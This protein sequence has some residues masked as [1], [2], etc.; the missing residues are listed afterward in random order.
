[1]SLNPDIRDRAYEF[2]IEEAQELLQ[3]LE[4]GLLEI[5]D[6]HSTPKVH[7][8]MRAAHSIK[9]G[10][11]SVELSAI[12]LLA[13]RLEDFFK[14]LYSDDIEFDGALESLLLQGYDCLSNPLTEQIES[15]A[16]DEEAALLSAEPVFAALEA[17]L[18]NA[19]KNAES[20][21]PSSNDLGVDIVSSIFE[22]DV[23]QSLEHLQEVAN[24]PN[25]YDLAE[26]LQGTL[27]MFA[28]FAELFSLPGFND[29]IQTAQ[30][31][32]ANNSDNAL[33]IIKA[34]IADCTLAKESVLAGDREQGGE[35]SNALIELAQASG[36]N[37]SSDN[38]ANFYA[39][40]PDDDMWSDNLTADPFA[41]DIFGTIPNAEVA[42]SEETISGEPSIENIGSI[43]DVFGA[44]PNAEVAASEDEVGASIEDIFGAIPD[45]EAV[46]SGETAPTTQN[47]DNIDSIDDVF[48]TI[49]D[50]EIAA[51]EEEVGAVDGI[52]DIFGSIP[53]VEA[54]VSE[55]TTPTQNT[56]N[57]DSIDE[58]F[59][60]IPDAE[61]AASE[62]EVGA[63]D[64]IEDIFGA[65]PDVEVTPKA[66]DKPLPH[67]NI[68]TAAESI[69]KIFDDLPIAESNLNSLTLPSAKETDKKPKASRAKSVQ[70]R[71]VQKAAAKLSV[72]VDLERLERMNNLVGELNINRNSLFLQNEQLQENVAELG[73]KF[74]RFRDVTQKLREISDRIVL[75]QRSHRSL[76][77]NLATSEGTYADTFENH[78]STEFDALEMDR[79]SGLYASIQNVLEEVVQLE[80]SVDDISIFAKQSDRTI[81]SQRQMLSQM[82]DELMW[83]RMLPLDQILQRFPRTL[84]DLSN[85]YQKPVDLKL[86]GTGVLV[87]KAVLEKLS[88]PLLHLLRNGFD[89]GIEPT[90]T[91]ISQG[92]NPTGKIEI[93]AYYQ[94]NQTVIE[95]KDDGKGLDVEKIAQKG[96]E[97][98]FISAAEVQTASKE[99][100]YD[101]IFEPGFSTANKVS[102]I[103]GRGVGMNIVRSQIESLKGKITVTS[104]PGEG[105]IFTLRLPLTLTIAKL[106]VC[107][108]GTTSFA[109]PSD[110]IEEIIIPTQEQIKLSNQQKFLS[111]G[112]KLVPI[113]CLKQLLQYNCPI[114]DLD[115][116]S[117]A[118]KTIKTPEDWFAPLLLLR[119]GQKLFALEVVSLLGEQEL[120]IKPYG[121]AIAAPQ[122]SYGCTILGDGSLIPAF[123]GATLI[124]TILGEEIAPITPRTEY[125]S[126]DTIIESDDSINSAD[127]FERSP[128]N[129]PAKKN[130]IA[131][132][133]IMVVDDSTALRRTMALTLEKHGYRVIQKKDGKDALDG[134]KQNPN[135]DLIICDVE[136][137]TM[138][139]FEFLGMRRRD[140]NLSQ[141]P[142]FMLTSRSG[143]KHRKLATQLGANG[144]FTKPYVEQEFILEVQKILSDKGSAR[145]AKSFESPSISKKTILVIDDSSALRRTLAFSLENKGYHVLQGR[146]GVEG[147]NLLRKNLQTSLVVCDVE[148]P[149][150]NGFEFLTSRR[151][152]SVLAKIPVVMLTSR[153]ADKHRSLAMS[154]GASGYFTKPYVEEQFMQD[155]A[156]FLNK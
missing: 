70:P 114:N 85:K 144:Y 115:S 113:Y 53:D 127:I 148:M 58:V 100:L 145:Q 8:L 156:V 54:V 111:L 116:T 2:F 102:E 29:I 134:F 43:D 50:A 13:H 98:G 120:V 73:Q 96:L 83:V 132:K 32:L 16:H 33:Q 108:L 110:S 125:A 140:S 6:D 141:V 146:D 86:T 37:S 23:V 11:A 121:K 48:G 71:K 15:G 155:L 97:K 14:A 118:F 47:T 56:D 136:M 28:G 149:N 4:S 17:R 147:L 152:E 60:A 92:K 64:G 21:I 72:R 126:E 93:H 51:S 128:N 18:E 139:G 63:V 87:D 69:E 104:S 112:G 61:I 12:E 103:S 79:Y 133:T 137:P 106:L 84:R 151:Q 39:E 9:G 142:T 38:A 91:R 129:N 46:F 42:A 3:V 89:H 62:E 40:N 105:S 36:L 68:E 94:G 66:S 65:I 82:R 41:E 55:E 88:D 135:L 59:G 7:E 26:E 76:G 35:V 138:N 19:L 124:G 22:V 25:D 143:A 77:S 99:R 52:E 1:M 49:P 131:T 119:K 45:V 10:A 107:S 154:L 95:V 31:A 75:E 5:R 122:Y 57:I 153:S 123:D 150:M 24:N 101:L 78:G 90:D 117:K 81:D 30:T 80:E 20:Y 130:K 27:E 67:E 109:I 44:I 74:I 34:T